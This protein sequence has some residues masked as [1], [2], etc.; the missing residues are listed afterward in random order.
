MARPAW[1]WIRREM[2]TWRIPIMTRFGKVTPAGV[3]TT[4]AG[5]AGTAGS[6]DG[7]GTTATFNFPSGVA[8]VTDNL[9]HV[10]VYVADYNNHTIR[11]IDATS[12]QVST[13]A[14][15]A[16]VSGSA[17][18]DGLLG[19]FQSSAGFD[20][21]RLRQS[22]RGGYG[23]P[24]HPQGHALR[25]GHDPGGIRRPRAAA[26]TAAAARPSS[27]ARPAWRSTAPATSMWRTP[28][29]TRSG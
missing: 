9:G 23:E 19:A 15:S 4:L 2:S 21:G 25:G 29:T 6:A 28:T 16:G 8:A 22:L 26:P 5:T 27:T 11:Q 7:T 18:G 20:G 17:D 10:T 14:G 1:R 13:L 12:G 3:A 24:R